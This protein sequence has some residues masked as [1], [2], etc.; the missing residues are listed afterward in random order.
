LIC[1]D[2]TG[3]T[4]DRRRASDD[5]D[6]GVS[7]TRLGAHVIFCVHSESGVLRTPFFSLFGIDGTVRSLSIGYTPLKELAD[8]FPVA[9]A[10]LQEP[11]DIIH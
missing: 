6:V 5:C 2:T 9:F 11:N 1:D 10:V 8:S 4:L 7:W 3:G